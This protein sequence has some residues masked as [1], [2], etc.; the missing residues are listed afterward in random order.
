MKVLL[1]NTKVNKV[2]YVNITYQNL[3]KST[4]V[5]KFINEN[6]KKGLSGL[7][8]HAGVAK[9]TKRFGGLQ[10]LPLSSVST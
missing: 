6:S 5:F 10:T 3:H 4:K 9:T 8:Q 7:Y 2:W 1:T